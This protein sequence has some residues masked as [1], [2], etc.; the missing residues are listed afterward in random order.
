MIIMDYTDTSKMA[1][2]WLIKK[3]NYVRIELPKAIALTRDNKQRN[4]ANSDF[5]I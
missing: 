2:K 5:G 4:T 3:Y 1:V